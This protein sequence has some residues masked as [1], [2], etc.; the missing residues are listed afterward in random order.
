M[1]GNVND[2]AETDF[3]VNVINEALREKTV[4]ELEHIGEKARQNRKALEEVVNEVDDVKAVAL[5]DR[6]IDMKYPGLEV[7]DKIS[8]LALGH[9]YIPCIEIWERGLAKKLTDTLTGEDVSPVDQP[10]PKEQ[11]PFYQTLSKRKTI[12]RDL[13]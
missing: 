9:P 10:E 2:D 12:P 5:L 13:E 8:L 1:S 6:Y 7:E 4:E 11:K 3:L